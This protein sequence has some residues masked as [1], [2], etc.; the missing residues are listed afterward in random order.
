MAMNRG[1]TAILCT[2]FIVSMLSASLDNSEQ[3]LPEMN[4]NESG[5]ITT[6]Q[7]QSRG[8]THIAT[9]EWWEPK[10]P[11]NVTA[12]D[13][14]GDGTINSN[15]DHPLNPAI[16][17][18]NPLKATSCTNHDNYCPSDP[19]LAIFSN[20]YQ[21]D[22]AG[23]HTLDLAWGDVDGDGDL[24][25]AVG[26]FGAP[27][28]VYINDGTKITSKTSWNSGDYNITIRVSWV[29]IDN[30][31]DLDLATADYQGA[32]Q[33]YR[34]ANGHIE[35]N[36]FWSFQY[37][38]NLASTISGMDWGDFDNDG[39]S[40]LL[41]GI[42]GSSL[43]IFKN[44]PQGMGNNPFWNLTA[45]R[46]TTDVAFA[47]MN[48][49]GKL[50]VVEG[51][52]NEKNN[53]YFNN[54]YQI[55]SIRGWWS[56]SLEPTSSIALG[57]VD[58]DGDI[59]LVVGN[60]Q[61]HNELYINGGIGVGLP[62]LPSWTSMNS[63]ATMD[64]SL[65][66]YDNDG[67][68][69]LLEAT[70]FG[71]DYIQQFI[72]D[73]SSFGISHTWSSQ[74]Q[75]DSGSVA[76][77]DV[78]GDGDLDFITGDGNDGILLN[79]HE[80]YQINPSH[81]WNNGALHYTKS[82]ELADM[83]GDNDLDI[84]FGN[85]L[86]AASYVYENTGSG[87]I[88]F[89]DSGQNPSYYV[90]DMIL[91]DV[92]DDG[93]KDVMIANYNG[94]NRAWQ[95][96]WSTSGNPTYSI[97]TAGSNSNNVW[98]SDTDDKTEDF[99]IGD[100]NGD[101]YDDI[102]EINDGYNRVHLMLSN[103][104]LNQLNDWSSS[105]T[106][107]SMCGALGDIN[108][109]GHL[110]LF[111]VNYAKS[112]MIY[113]NNGMG[114][115]E[116]T[117]SWTT[118]SQYYGQS[119]ALGD[120][121]G[122]SDIDAIIGTEYEKNHLFLN[123]NG[124]LSTNPD[125]STNELEDTTSI[126]LWD[127]DGDGDLDWV[128]GNYDY[129]R[130]KIRV[131]ENGDF[132]ATI[133]ESTEALKTRSIKMAD[134]DGDGDLDIVS[135]DDGTANLIHYS[136]KDQDGDW[137]SEN[138]GDS[139]PFDPTQVSDMDG[140]G[141]GD[142]IDGWRPDHCPTTWGD[143]WR[144]RWGCADLDGDGQSDLFDPFMQD[145]TQ[146]SDIDGDGLGDNW[147][148]PAISSLRENRLLGEFFEN[149]TI[150]DPSP[151]D[152]DNDGFED[153][154]LDGAISPFD[155]CPYHA[156]TSVSD[157]FGCPDADLDGHSDEGDAFPGDSTQW[158][159]SDGDNYGDNDKGNQP[160]SCSL[161]A[162]SSTED[163]FGCPDTDGDGWSDEGDFNPDNPAIWSDDDSDGFDDQLSDGCLNDKGSSTEDRGGCKDHDRDGYSDP[164]SDSS[165]HPFGDADA[166]PFDG[167]QWRNQDGD[168]Y[169]DNQIG[170]QPDSCTD[171]YGTSQ[172]KITNGEFDDWYG[173]SDQDNDGLY[174]GDDQCPLVGGTSSIDR[175]GCPDSDN[176]GMSDLND[177]CELQA[178]DSTIEFIACPD[179]D[180]D[181][182][183]DSIDPEPSDGRGSADDW[184][185]DGWNQ[186]TDAFPYDSTQWEDADGDGLG[187]N[188]NGSNPDLLPGDKDNDGWP[189]EN[190]TFINNPNEWL[191]T[192][193]DG[194]GDNADTDD[195]GDGYSDIFEVQDGTD[196]KD[197][198]SHAV[199]SWE[200][201]IP[202]TRIGLSWWD[203]VGILA[204]LP[205][206]SWLG[207]GLVTRNKRVAEF[208]KELSQATTKEGIEEVAIRAEHALMLRLIGPHQAIR[209]ERLRAEL[210]DALGVE[211]FPITTEQTELVLDDMEQIQEEAFV[212]E[213]PET[214]INYQITE[215]DGYEWRNENGKFHYRMKDGDG[216]WLPWGE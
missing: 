74:S 203:L 163:Q 58:N 11:F 184:D 77:G 76:W 117:A 37:G 124:A 48:G 127:V 72:I 160:D 100:I 196:P 60:R 43:L 147:N 6:H 35:L 18:N 82:V 99:V 10:R 206:A 175:F 130:N 87:F 46:L 3:L 161:I 5:K 134:L 34:N 95:G 104:Y 47:D 145:Y 144:S 85:S 107:D 131:N 23:S 198:N 64:V 20:N 123:N 12:I 170:F 56:Q 159:D 176:D 155:A 180:G 94:D 105:D 102:V 119:C 171:T 9:G 69:D 153:E 193:G 32:V 216:V 195:D 96:Y 88:P 53:I 51:V 81:D 116:T 67:D 73:S 139:A 187:D 29:D 4:E 13:W 186:T 19:N 157:R 112:A 111:V 52:A 80:G 165:S 118:A 177:D 128:E 142:L 59:D 62:T 205:L 169:G 167:T 202:G 15:D 68:L 209:L 8:G 121:D 192:D 109:D 1:Y 75:G 92:N 78:D 178:G 164:D 45:N 55:S 200:L 49:D 90:N 91:F 174:D 129:E 84:L 136:Q 158:N 181:G 24:D 120:I 172:F 65:G 113:Y 41:L 208:E 25:V 108:G 33:I 213:I 126:G 199:E 61:S 122:D 201:M 152:Y 16:P 66:D 191:D 50:D 149:A 141:F 212:P 89:W 42:A 189:D 103:G 71:H 86:G 185:A 204:G 44:K 183:P 132:T 146:W 70:A 106:S 214:S 151:W 79:V 115:L 211:G 40:D 2:L 36:P 166:F 179:T 17:H 14:D 114:S 182:I 93:A 207:F 98:V 133:W 210:D 137:I 168:G 190:D 38:N 188:P 138:D 28:Y 101:G 135:A 7:N 30:D 54:N 148:D 21:I 154:H 39:D 143:S 97:I 162:G 156:G 173:C 215:S 194:V 140:D 63:S 31:G 197:A 22:S 83:D 125:W 57:D 150:P 26:N 27:N 110:D